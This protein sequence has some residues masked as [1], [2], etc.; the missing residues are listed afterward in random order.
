M[1]AVKSFAKI[2]WLSVLAASLAACGGGGGDANS[3]APAGGVITAVEN[4]MPVAAVAFGAGAMV[5]NDT[6]RVNPGN[7]LEVDASGSA[8]PDGDPLTFTWQI[9]SKPAGSKAEILTSGAKSSFTPDLQG[10]YQFTVTVSDG[11]GGTVAK[12]VEFMGEKSPPK[13]WAGLY[14]LDFR[15]ADAVYTRVQNLLVLTTTSPT[16]ALKIVDPVSKAT[17]T[18]DLPKSINTFAVS[19]DGLHA[20][21]AHDALVSYIDLKKGVLI[22]TVSVAMSASS[23]VLTNDGIAYLAGSYGGGSWNDTMV[24]DLPNAFVL[25]NTAEDIYWAYNSFYGSVQG[26]MA[27][28]KNRFYVVDRDISPNDIHFLEYD[29]VSHNYVKGGDSP[30]HADYAMGSALWLNEDQSIVFT[31]AGTTFNADTL[32]YAGRIDEIAGAT[33]ISQSQAADELLATINGVNASNS[34]DSSPLLLPSYRRL[35]GQYYQKAADVTLPLV[36]MYQSYAMK[37]FHSA[38]GKHIVLVQVGS[39]VPGAAASTYHV[40]YR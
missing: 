38:A 24:V 32:T 2:F 5:V 27:A 18:V 3:K 8:D 25:N 22:R 4:N 34:F 35:V 17:T 13:D 9:V 36:D 33:S 6:L 19:P 23:I 30:Y 40:I 26:V 16:A 28:N 12:Q 7:K 11:K 31:N 20:A 14:S 15:P 39:D 10:M 37:V 29:P 1:A 21:V